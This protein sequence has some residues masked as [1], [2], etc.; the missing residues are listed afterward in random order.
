M[1][2]S[3]R[4]RHAAS[5]RDMMPAFE[6]GLA[7]AGGLLI[8]G[9]GCVVAALRPGPAQ[10][11]TQTQNQ[12][13]AT[14]PAE[15]VTVQGLRDAAP[16]T[17]EQFAPS[18][19]SLDQTQ[20]T[21]TVTA[22]ALKKILVPT[23]DY[24]D[25]V[26]LTPSAMNINPVGPGLQQDFG[27]SIRGLQYTEFSVLFDGIQIPGFPFN[28]APQ[29]GAYFLSRDF[30]SVTVNRG[31][32]PAST[33]G[34]ATFGG[35][36]ALTSP[37][38]ATLPELETYGTFGSFGTK[39]FGAQAQTGTLDRYGG[40]S[41]LLDLTRE[42]ARGAL[43]GVRT[44]R[45]NLF[46]K[47]EQPIGPS[48]VV[49]LVV[50]LDSDD[51]KTPY[52]ATLASMNR[53]GRNFALNSDP[54][55]QTFNGYNRDNYSTDFEYVSVRSVLGAGWVLDDRAYTTA[56]DQRSRH[57][58]DPGGTAPN[59][60]GT[61]SLGGVD[62]VV[63]N[64]VPGVSSQ[65]DYRNWGNILRLSKDTSTGQFR[66]GVWAERE[67]F[68]TN[69]V[70]VDF[71][72]NA[73]AYSAAA[74]LSPYLAHYYASLVTAQPYAEYAWKPISTVTLTAGVKYSS[75]TRYLNGPITLT[76]RPADDHATY[77]RPLPS[78]DGNWRVANGLSLFA[79]AAEG[80]L[81]PP[82]NLFSATDITAVQPSTTWS[83]QVG[84]VFQ[85]AWLKL[86]VDA[87]DIDFHNYIASNTVAGFT[88]YFNQGGATFKGVEV[89]GTVTL[90]HGFAAYANGSLNDATYGNNGNNL[91]Q[92]PR[93]TA[94]LAL[95]YDRNGIVRDKDELFGNATIKSVGPQYG[96]DTAF[97]GAADQFPI[98]SYNEL[99]LNAGYVLPLPHVRL[100]TSV[101]VTNL[102]NH[103]SLTGYGGQTLEGA[104]L[105]WVQAG[106]GI[107]FS[108]A[109]F[110]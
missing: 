17:A 5:V 10:A 13:Q 30:G 62:T 103:R 6:Q 84:T 25:V 75:V 98:K 54:T 80:F 89:E 91:A 88:T 85:R 16:V 33:I 24:D 82:L 42:E 52:G 63:D 90:G 64:D 21:S 28:L 43:S 22:D 38:L 83:Y 60:S 31:P 101:N 4:Q 36:V 32:G 99:D 81:T 44:E 55:S 76:G 79:Q 104:P 73:Q 40:G 11:Q 37:T 100:R 95:L 35:S 20:P 107:F 57:G 92:T 109:A 65:Y 74:G 108:V 68:T 14:A 26:T 34:S 96:L 70:S 2:Q 53:F 94:A 72:R 48:T 71:T 97:K 9:T 50:N 59:L 56:Y 106:R 102:L 86:G 8:L 77:N 23:A 39:L 18:G 29:P 58:L 12:A 3:F 45:R 47:A 87:Y 27:Q 51:T 15:Q 78:F 69:T 66:V 41:I 110:L 1:S 105:Y 19:P 61:I 93:R 49:T 46:L 7:R 67:G